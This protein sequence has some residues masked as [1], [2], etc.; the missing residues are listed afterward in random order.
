MKTRPSKSLVKRLDMDSKSRRKMKRSEL[1]KKSLLIN[2]REFRKTSR[3]S[4]M[5]SPKRQLRAV[6]T[7]LSIRNLLMRPKLN[8]SY[9]SSTTKVY[10]IVNCNVLRDSIA[11]MRESLTKKSRN[12]KRTSRLREKSMTR[13]GIILR[14]ERL[15]SMKRP[16]RERT[17]KRRNQTS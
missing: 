15:R 16:R 14:E 13:S 6:K 10:S 8:Q 2:S 1:K 7:S 12:Y 4:K 3:S 17:R 5:S 9:L 11:E